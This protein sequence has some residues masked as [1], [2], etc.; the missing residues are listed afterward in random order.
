M[1][2]IEIKLDDVSLVK[3]SRDYLSNKVVYRYLSFKKDN[4]QGFEESKGTVSQFKQR[5]NHLNDETIDFIINK[6]D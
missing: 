4:K 3:F 6:L 2:A 5:Y 1:K